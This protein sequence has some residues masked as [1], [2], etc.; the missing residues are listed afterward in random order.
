MIGSL[1]LAILSFCYLINNSRSQTSND[2]DDYVEASYNSLSQ[3]LNA[4]RVVGMAF[5]LKFAKSYKVVF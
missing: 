1:P 2:P 3:A 4:Q 5:W